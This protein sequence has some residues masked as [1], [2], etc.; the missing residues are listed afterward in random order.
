M[1]ILEEN[2][3]HKRKMEKMDK[4]NECRAQW[5]VFLL[6]C[7]AL[8]VLLFMC[9][10]A[11]VNKSWSTMIIAMLALIAVIGYAKIQRWLR[12]SVTSDSADE[13]T[14]ANLDSRHKSSI[15]SGSVDEQHPH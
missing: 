3:A 10:L 7:L 1:V 2:L 9:W 4:D 13:R 15:A 11:F 12:S 8:G 14:H 6:S 5:F